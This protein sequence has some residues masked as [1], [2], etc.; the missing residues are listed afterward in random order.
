MQNDPAG[1]VL[2]DLIET[3]EDGHKGFATAAEKLEASG[4]P[5]LARTMGE[6]SAQRRRFS[7]ELRGV[8][9]SIGHEIEENGSAAGALHRGWIA[10][11]DALTGDDAHAILAAA[12]SGED[13]AVSE[14]E[15][16]LAK[17]LPAQIQDVVAKQA[18]EVRAAHDTVRAMRDQNE[19]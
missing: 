10:V 18:A 9:R 1:A 12:E 5:N 19:K 15:D 11:K 16:A 4:H 3:L 2:E 7:D 13:H 6:Y 14:Y 17:E 8:A